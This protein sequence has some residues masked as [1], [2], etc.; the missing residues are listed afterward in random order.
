MEGRG[1]RRRWIVGRCREAR[2]RRFVS[3]LVVR[4]FGVE[5]ENRRRS[6][7]ARRSFFGNLR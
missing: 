1:R 4:V 5:R 6:E 2:A 3:S 7:E